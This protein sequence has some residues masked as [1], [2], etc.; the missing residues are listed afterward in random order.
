M[1][2]SSPIPRWERVTVVVA[3]YVGLWIAWRS[4]LDVL[5]EGP[6]YLALLL[7]TVACGAVVRHPSVVLL[8]LVPVAIF[9][10]HEAPSGVNVVDFFTPVVAACAV[11]GAELGRRSVHRARDL[12]RPTQG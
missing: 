11:V 6:S 1:A 2:G 4:W 10:G 3:A 12:E 8:G 5:P 7:A 9:L